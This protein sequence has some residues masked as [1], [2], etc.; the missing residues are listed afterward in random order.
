VK[1]VEKQQPQRRAEDLEK[2]EEPAELGAKVQEAMERRVKTTEGKKRKETVEPVF[3][4]LNQEQRVPAVS[5]E[6]A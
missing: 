6:G 3:G 4:R 1:A 2:H 5:A